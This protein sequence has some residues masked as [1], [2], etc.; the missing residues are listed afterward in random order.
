MQKVLHQ[1]L[2]HADETVALLAL[3]FAHFAQVKSG[4]E[5]NFNGAMMLKNFP[6][7]LKSLV[8]VETAR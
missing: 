7:L 1:L 4:W 8:H 6:L 3:S 5:E 2:P